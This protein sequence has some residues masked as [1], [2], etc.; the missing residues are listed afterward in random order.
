MVNYVVNLTNN[1]DAGTIYGTVS[2]TLVTWTSPGGMVPVQTYLATNPIVSAGQYTVALPG[3]DDITEGP[4]GYSV[5][6]VGLA[7]NGTATL[8]GYLAD[9]TPVS[10]VAQ[11]SALGICPIYIPLYANGTGGLLMGRLTFTNDLAEYE[12]LTTNSSLIWFNANGATPNLY[13]LGFTNEAVAFACTY[14]TNGSYYTDALGSGSSS[15]YGY[16]VF[17]G[18]NLGANAVVK[19]VGITNNVI[20]PIS[21]SDQANLSLTINTN[22]GAITGSYRELNKPIHSI[23]SIQG[24]IFQ[25]GSYSTGYFFGSNTNE[26]GLFM[27]FGE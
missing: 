24:A 6:T 21:L 23:N 18:G 5:F 8:T 25:N 20:T 27:L 11:L 10:Q 13:P 22:T 14:S 4:V 3:F 12:S 15:G 7:T 9:N 16:V 26:S 2:N 17:S 1:T 19:K